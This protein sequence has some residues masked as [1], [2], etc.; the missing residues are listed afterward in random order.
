MTYLMN[1][2]LGL[3]MFASIV[4]GGTPGE[5]LSGRAASAA[6]EGKLRGK[7]LVA[8][9]DFI[10]RNRGHCAAALKGDIERAKAVIADQSK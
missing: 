9:I 4:L 8:I 5:T 7:I 2:L 1:V 10:A 6:A 3:D